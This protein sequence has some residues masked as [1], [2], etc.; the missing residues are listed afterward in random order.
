METHLAAIGNS[1]GVRIPKS[2]REQCGLKDLVKLTVTNDGLLISPINT[3]RLGWE[4]A[5]LANPPRQ[6]AEFSE[7]DAVATT[8]DDTEWTWPQRP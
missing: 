4:E 8:F 1:K 6:E 7:F 2:V 3:P 5:L